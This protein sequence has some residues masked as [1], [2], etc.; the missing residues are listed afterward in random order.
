MKVYNYQSIERE[1]EENKPG[2]GVF[3]RW[4]THLKTKAS[5][6]MELKYQFTL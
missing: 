5:I 2:W 4:L 1:N 6:L 3:S